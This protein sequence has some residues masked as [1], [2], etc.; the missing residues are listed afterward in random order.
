MC[1]GEGR[2]GRDAR[3]RERGEFAGELIVLLRVVE[4]GG[5][6]KRI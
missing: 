1:C 2:F 4:G 6:F 3:V 5:A